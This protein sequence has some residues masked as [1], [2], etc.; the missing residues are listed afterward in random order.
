MGKLSPIQPVQSDPERVTIFTSSKMEALVEVQKCMVA[1]FPPEK[2]GITRWIACEKWPGCEM[3]ERCHFVH[4]R[5]E[6]PQ[7]IRIHSDVSPPE[8]MNRDEGESI[9]VR[10]PLTGEEKDVPAVCVIPTAALA[11]P[12]RCPAFEAWGYCR[13]THGCPYAH[14]R[15]CT[16][17][18][19]PHLHLRKPQPK[20]IACM[21]G[22]NNQPVTTGWRRHNPYENILVSETSD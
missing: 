6:L 21:N 12:L 11:N 16:P 7:G 15:R 4:L 19:Q 22:G 18:G 9:T 3:G 5:C 14:V 1:H 10:D 20:Y 17:E 2:K 13:R 8:T